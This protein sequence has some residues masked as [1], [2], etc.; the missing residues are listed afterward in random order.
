MAAEFVVFP[1]CLIV[2][3]LLVVNLAFAYIKQQPF[4]KGLWRGS[5][6]LVFTQ[7]LFYPAVIL[8]AVLGGVNFMPGNRPNTVASLFVD[9]LSWA[10][11]ALAIFWVW[12]MKGLRWVAFS[13]VAL[14]EFLFCGALFTAGMAISGRWL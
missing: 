11:L 12:R 2:F 3:A 10:S 5:F 7:I 6:W 13:L 9:V 8:I 1:P 4:R 14:Q